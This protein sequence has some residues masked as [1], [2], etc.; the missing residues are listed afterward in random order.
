MEIFIIIL[1]LAGAITMVQNIIWYA[2][3]LKNTHDVLSSGNKSDTMWRWTGFLLLIFFL[4]GYV[5]IGIFSD[6]DLMMA[7]V[8][9]F[10]SIFVT[11]VLFIMFKLLDNVKM[12]SLDIT[13]ALI[14]VIDAR[15]PNLNGHSVHVQRVS[16][17]LYNYLPESMKREVNL[18]SLEYASLMHDIGKLGVPESILNKPD[19][20]TDE[21]WKIMK[22]HPEIGVKLLQPLH[23]FEEVDDWIYCHHER[24]DG[25]GYY[26]V[27][28]EDIPLAARIISVADTYSAITMRRSYKKPKTHEDAIAIMKEVAGSQ[29]DS[30]LV[31]IFFTIPKEELEKCIPEEVK[32]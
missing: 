3:F 32:Y 5:S 6:P 27:K 9:L 15:D 23:G 29:L 21:E 1:I 18:I 30:Q 16:V 22:Q 10:G 17:L 24:I 25:K 4:I 7:M 28:K 20:L 11:I 8:L 19:K 12:R 2:N 13:K 31:D 26:N 14:S